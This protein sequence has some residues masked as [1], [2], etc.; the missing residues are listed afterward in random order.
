MQGRA[1]TGKESSPSS[2]RRKVGVLRDNKAESEAANLLEE[3]WK[4]RK[5]NIQ[6]TLLE[7]RR[8]ENRK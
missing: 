3:A 8:A 4:G 5:H 1:T 7:R 6:Q 2:E